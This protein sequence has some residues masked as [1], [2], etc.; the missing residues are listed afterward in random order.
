[1]LNYL[2]EQQHQCRGFQWLFAAAAG[3]GKRS[4]AAG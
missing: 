1:M 4:S 3:M 2:Q